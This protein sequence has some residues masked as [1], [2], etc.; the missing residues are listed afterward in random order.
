MEAEESDTSGMSTTEAVVTA[1]VRAQQ[2]KQ[3][4]THP[5]SELSHGSLSVREAQEA[6]ADPEATVG[7]SH[8]VS[9]RSMEIEVSTMRAASHRAT[10]NQ[11]E[12]P[13]ANTLLWLL[14][15]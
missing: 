4:G 15:T 8:R 14:L 1:P 6:V 9:K 2:Q 5:A 11:R 10:L 3:S 7:R 13:I 12:R